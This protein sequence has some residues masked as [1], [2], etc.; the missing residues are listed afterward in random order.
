MAR[1]KSHRQKPSRRK[2][3]RQFGWPGDRPS[4]RILKG[5]LVWPFV[6]S[7]IWGRNFV[8]GVPMPSLRWL[9][10]QGGREPGV[11]L[12]PVLFSFLIDRSLSPT[13]GPARLRLF[14]MTGTS[15]P[16][17]CANI[18]KGLTLKPSLKGIGL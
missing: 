5:L 8:V 18:D 6:L 15:G 4:D 3:S 11:N 17:R 10:G 13:A 16:S 9:M 14:Q 1:M 7:G 12:V 2:L